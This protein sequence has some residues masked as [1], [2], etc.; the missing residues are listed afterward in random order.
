MFL[1]ELVKFSGIHESFQIVQSSNV[2]HAHEYVRKGLHSCERSQSV[3]DCFLSDRVH[4]DSFEWNVTSLKNLLSTLA[5]WIVGFHPHRELSLLQNIQNISLDIVI[6]F[7]SLRDGSDLGCVEQ[8][9]CD[10]VEED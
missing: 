9:G 5:E 8:I 7:T 6:N 4:F 1:E 10:S 3:P 2:R